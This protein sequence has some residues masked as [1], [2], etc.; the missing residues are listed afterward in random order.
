VRRAPRV[1]LLAGF[2]SGLVPASAH[3]EWQFAPFGGFSFGGGTNIFLTEFPKS[4][5][6][7]GGTARLIGAGPLGVESL[8]IY[9]PGTFRSVDID[10]LFLDSAQPSESITKSH[11]FAFMGNVVLT[12]PRAWNQYGLRP[13]VSGGM[14]LLQVYH[15]EPKVPA[16]ANLPAYNVGGGAVGLLSDRVG[17]RFELRYFSTTPHGREPSEEILTNDN[18]R[19]RVHFWAATMGV[20]FK[21]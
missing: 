15:N 13:Y 5:W 6:T 4:H 18:E 2:L 7:F 19:V 14:G 17:L 21:Y 9:V 3:A 1:L 16:R 20:V 8:F 10:P 12:T 11:A